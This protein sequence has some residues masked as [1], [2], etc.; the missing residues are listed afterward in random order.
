[1]DLH[2][3]GSL[4]GGFPKR[5]EHP[6]RLEGLHDEI[7]RTRLNGLHDH[8]LLAHRGAHHHVGARIDGADLLEGGDAVH[9]GHRDVHRH[10][11]RAE[12]LELFHGLG[13][14]RR[15]AHDLV[16]VLGVF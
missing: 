16:A 14:V 4:S 10:D 9:L 2:D 5:F 1:M 15:L 3:I 8:V 11:V 13:A 6:I 7:A 12:L